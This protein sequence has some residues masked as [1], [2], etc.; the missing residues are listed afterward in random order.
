MDYQ[1]VNRNTWNRMADAGS[2]F[3]RTASDEDCR[4]PLKVLDGRGWLPDSVKDLD[5]LCLA[6]GGG[7]Q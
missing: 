4:T 2:L 7:W 3:A 6:S 5:V 1:K